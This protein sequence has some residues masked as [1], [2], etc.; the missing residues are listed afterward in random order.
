MEPKDEI[1]DTAYFK[2]LRAEQ[3][4]GSIPILEGESPSVGVKWTIEPD[5]RYIGPHFWKATGVIRRTPGE[6]Y[7]NFDLPEQFATE[8]EAVTAAREYA[9]DWIAQQP[10][11]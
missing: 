4:A 2:T 5:A 9:Q 6:A 1:D 3:E 10:V 11:E 8:V 7:W